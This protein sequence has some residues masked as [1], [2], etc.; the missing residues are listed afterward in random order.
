M[1]NSFRDK[2]NFTNDLQIYVVKTRYLLESLSA[3]AFLMLVYVISD[4]LYKTKLAVKA[5]RYLGNSSSLNALEAKEYEKINKFMEYP[6]INKE[7][8]LAL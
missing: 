6:M 3:L 8:G 5:I 4:I 1:F 7:G 2:A